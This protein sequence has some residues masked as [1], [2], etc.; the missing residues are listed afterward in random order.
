MATDA[1]NHLAV[2]RQAAS[3]SPDQ[4]FEADQRARDAHRRAAKE[5]RFAALDSDIYC[6]MP[7]GLVMAN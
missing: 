2:L 4:L 1:D 3:V 6:S 5:F 7:S